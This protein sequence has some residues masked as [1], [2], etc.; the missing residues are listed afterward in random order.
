MASEGRTRVE[1]MISVDPAQDILR[2]QAWDYFELD[3]GQRLTTFNFYIVISAVT[4]TAL[5]ATFQKDYRIPRV[6][7][8]LGFLLALFSFVFW[9]LD[10]RNKDLIKRAEAALRFFESTSPPG[11]AEDGPHITKVSSREKYDTDQKKKGGG[12]LGLKRPLSYSDCFNI[13]LLAFGLLGVGGAFLPLC[14]G[15]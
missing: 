5:F 9:K 6:G 10:S 15:V 11:D 7:I 1:P 2:K 13:V 8:L 14:M 4:A 12:V 3:A